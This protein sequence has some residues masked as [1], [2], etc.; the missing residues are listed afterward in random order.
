MSSQDRGHRTQIVVAVI[1]LV[2]TIMVDIEVEVRF[3]FF[4][5]RKLGKGIESP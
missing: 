1:G 4:E 5:I 2:G 3:D